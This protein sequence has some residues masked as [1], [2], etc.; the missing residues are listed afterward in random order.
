MYFWA[1][2]YPVFLLFAAVFVFMG[3]GETPFS[4]M[5]VFPC[6]HHG[7]WL[8]IKVGAFKASRF[9]EDVFWGMKYL[10]LKPFTTL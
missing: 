1:G 9:S 8:I 2:L 4:E 3:G 10:T 6:R 5:V 7:C